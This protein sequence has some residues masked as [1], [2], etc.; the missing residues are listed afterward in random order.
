MPVSGV[1]QDAPELAGCVADWGLGVGDV[2]LIER[3]AKRVVAVRVEQTSSMYGMTAR[4]F[5][6][7]SRH[8]IVSSLISLRIWFAATTTCSAAGEAP[9]GGR[10]VEG[11]GSGVVGGI[12]SRSISGSMSA[13][14]HRGG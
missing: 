14:G 2:E 4:S 5:G 8:R 9:P 13:R 1:G 6:H 12:G 11:A 3:T 10:V 7:A